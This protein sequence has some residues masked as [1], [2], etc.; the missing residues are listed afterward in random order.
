MLR[1]LQELWDTR[2]NLGCYGFPFPPALP[3]QQAANAALPLQRAANALMPRRSIPAATCL[4]FCTSLSGACSAVGPL[5]NA[6]QPHPLPHPDQGPVTVTGARR[7][8]NTTFRFFLGRCS[9]E[10][11]LPAVR[12]QCKVLY[13]GK[14]SNPSFGPFPQVC[15]SITGFSKLLVHLGRPILYLSPIFTHFPPF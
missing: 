2:A 4:R 12:L 1:I 7:R 15:C 8:G 13:V 6:H 3:L 14:Y 10:T 9:W 5:G 11:A